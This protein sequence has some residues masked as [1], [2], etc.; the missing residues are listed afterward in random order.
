MRQTWQADPDRRP[1]FGQVLERL[2]RMNSSITSSW[3]VCYLVS[4]SAHF[5]VPFD[6]PSN[7]I[8]IQ[9]LLFIGIYNSIGAFSF[10]QNRLTNIS[11]CLTEFKFTMVII[12][13]LCFLFLFLSMSIYSFLIYV[14]LK[15]SANLLE[16]KQNKMINLCLLFL[17]QF[18]ICAFFLVVW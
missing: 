8:I 14:Q 16:T 7:V 15:Y 18:L 6:N 3:F 4:Y 12:I 5:F 9:S 1:S 13:C 10:V 17:F 2:K 11:R